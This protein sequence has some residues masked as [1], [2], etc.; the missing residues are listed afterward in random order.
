MFT[1]SRRWKGKFV[2]LAAAGKEADWFMDLISEF[3]EESLHLKIGTHCII[4]RC[5]TK[6]TTYVSMECR[7]FKKLG[8]GFLYAHEGI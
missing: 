4:P 2:A 3:N 5:K 6:R 7:R 1:D 8:L